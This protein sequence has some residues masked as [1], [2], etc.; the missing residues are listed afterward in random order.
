[1]R[2]YGEEIWQTLRGGAATYV[3]F[4]VYTGMVPAGSA[5]RKLRERGMSLCY[6]AV[7]YKAYMPDVKIARV[8]ERADGVVRT[9]TVYETPVGTVSE[10]MQPAAYGSMRRIEHPIKS[11]DDY[12]VAEFMARNRLYEPACEEFR[13]AEAQLGTDGYIPGAAGYSPIMEIEVVLLG[14]ERFCTEIL[15][16][17]AEVMSL[18]EALRDKQREMYRVVAQSPAEVCRYGGNIMPETLGPERIEK[19]VCPCW[20]EFADLMHEEGKML[21]VHLDANNRLLLDLVARS[22]L[23]MI[24]AF[25]PPPD[26]DTSVAEARAAWPGKVLSLNFPSSVHLRETEEI[27]TVTR[28]L[29][30]EAGDRRGFIIGITENVPWDVLDRSLSAILD[31]INDCPLD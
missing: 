22:E 4:T 14:I 15:D 12:A 31:V 24:E 18:Y 1:M 29:I 2:D 9:R 17:E 21:A 30:E 8:E 6:C 20:Q 26:C 7:P 5:E 23:D 16:H 25:T 28:Q 3:P 19:Y 11:L 13:E 27:R 10:L